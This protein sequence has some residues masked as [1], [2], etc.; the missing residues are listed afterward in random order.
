MKTILD[1][2]KLFFPDSVLDKIVNYINIFI[3]TQVPKFSKERDSEETSNSELKAV[4]GL[5]Y[6]A[7][8]LRSSNQNLIDIWNDDGTGVDAF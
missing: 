1:V 3:R 2:Q 7:G 4:L 6:T 5:L 8:V